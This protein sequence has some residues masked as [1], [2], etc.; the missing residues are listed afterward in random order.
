MQ[1]GV[2][3]S[4]VSSPNGV[5]GRTPSAEIKFGAFYICCMTAIL[6]IFQRALIL[7]FQY[8]INA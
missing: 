1:L 4:T 2:W 3:G 5:W 6:L 7:R 8:A